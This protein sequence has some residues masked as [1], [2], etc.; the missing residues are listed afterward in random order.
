MVKLAT[1][2]PPVKGGSVVGRRHSSR[3]Y[4]ETPKVLGV[5]SGV[6]LGLKGSG[7]VF[8]MAQA[9]LTL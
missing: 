7:I 2:F 8:L 5:P 9:D 4:P 3:R 6:G 1:L